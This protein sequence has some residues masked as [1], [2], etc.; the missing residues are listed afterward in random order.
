MTNITWKVKALDVI[1]SADNLNNVVK[2]VHVDVSFTGDDELI[3]VF[4][5]SCVLNSPS[6]QE[7]VSFDG[8]T[9]DIVI[10]WV[11]NLMG[12]EWV[13]EVE[14]RISTKV[15]TVDNTQPVLMTPP[16]NH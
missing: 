2:V 3:S 7:F 12:P 5:H 15:S 14:N 10:G 13:A 8:L 1:P 9:E 6:E 11:K 16:W 4:S